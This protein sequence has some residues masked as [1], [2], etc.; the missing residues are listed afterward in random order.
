M[1]TVI[2]KKIDTTIAALVA[3]SR[4]HFEAKLAEY[5]VQLFKALCEKEKEMRPQT[6][7][8]KFNFNFCVSMTYTTESGPLF[9]PV[10]VAPPAPRTYHLRRSARK[11]AG[12]Y[13]E[14]E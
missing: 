8:A 1:S 9:P 3:Q 6:V 13:A 7:D 2:Q 11:P 14:A 5:Q 12:F 10:P 4:A